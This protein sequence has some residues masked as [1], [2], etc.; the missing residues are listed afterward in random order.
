MPTDEITNNTIQMN[1]PAWYGSLPF[2]R[3]A[4]I[5][6][7]QQDQ[8][9]LLGRPTTKYQHYPLRI[10]QHNKSSTLPRPPKL[11]L[12]KQKREDNKVSCY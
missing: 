1:V 9:I 3:R 8:E 4:T 10:D 7:R 2:K 12:Y 5:A 11:T 6:D